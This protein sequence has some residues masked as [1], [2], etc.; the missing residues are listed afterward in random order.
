M[1][2]S[3]PHG[4]VSGRLGLTGDGSHG[5]CLSEGVAFNKIAG[6][7]VSRFLDKVYITVKVCRTHRCIK[8]RHCLCGMSVT[9]WMSVTVTCTLL[10]LCIC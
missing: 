3:W 10:L 6:D 2:Q 4:S 8:R 1:S 7:P 9:V 5:K